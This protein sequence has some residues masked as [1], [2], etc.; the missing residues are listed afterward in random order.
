[1][2][3]Y[4]N[5]TSF[6]INCPKCNG[7]ITVKTEQIG[8]HINCQYCGSQIELEDDGFSDELNS[9]NQSIDKFMKDLKNMFK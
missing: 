3:N 6:N 8:T 5:N 1:M 9:A 4:F 7:Q 2:S